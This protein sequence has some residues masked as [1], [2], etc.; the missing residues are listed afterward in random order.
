MEGI[1]QN[2]FKIP[3]KQKLSNSKQ[4]LKYST[5]ITVTIFSTAVFLCHSTL[6]AISQNSASHSFPTQ[7]AGL[8]TIYIE[9]NT[10]F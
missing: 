8:G 3:Q 2:V 6:T 1:I 9:T 4:S 10:C 5:F 7:E